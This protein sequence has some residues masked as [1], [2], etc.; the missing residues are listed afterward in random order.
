MVP[1]MYAALAILLLAIA[2]RVAGAFDLALSNISP[3]MA[4][5]F[6]GAVYS[7]RRWLWLVP[8][9]ALL[10]SDIFINQHYQSQYGFDWRI[11]GFIARSA[12]FA[13]AV[14]LGRRIS[15]RKSWLW[16]LNGSLLGALVFY[17][18]TNTQSWWSD[19]FYARS[20][21]GWWQALTIGHPQY[22]PTYL[23]LLRS[24]FGDIMF[25]GLFAGLMEWMA[26][27]R[28][29]PSLLDPT[30]DAEPGNEA[31]EGEAEETVAD[32]GN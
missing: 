6:C 19:L 32:A 31:A 15:T 7:K 4:I 5:T 26:S 22:P 8:F 10:A 14:W 13:F 1:A 18:V 3:L 25:T 24:L 9:V 30:E 27:S 20:A 2:Y 17:L 29:E 11:S 28:G 21:A 16:L 12:C 23:F